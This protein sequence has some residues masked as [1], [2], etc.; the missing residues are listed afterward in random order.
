MGGCGS[1]SDQRAQSPTPVCQQHHQGGHAGGPAGALGWGAPGYQV[2][3]EA[4]NPSDPP[5]MQTVAPSGTTWGQYVR[6]GASFVNP[7]TGFLAGP[8]AECISWA[9]ILEHS[10]DWS[11]MPQYAADGVVG[12]VLQSLENSL[13][14]RPNRDQILEAAQ[15]LEDASHQLMDNGQP[16]PAINQVVTLPANAM[17][18]Q[19]CQVQNFQQPGTMMTVQVPQNA[20]PGQQ[21]MAPAPVQPH[22]SGGMS[23]GGK[24]ALAAGGAVAVGA[25]AGAAYY[26]TVGG[27]MDGLVGDVGAAGGAIGDAAGGAADWAGGAADDVGDWVGGAAGDVGD[28]AGGAAADVGEFGGEAFDGAGDFI[29]DLF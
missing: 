25:L 4:P 24:V 9:V 17:P 8:W 10:N 19:P 11:K 28:W 3:V 5:F 27:G 15:R 21:I 29:G 14:S 22:Q 20:G 2:R 6:T 16:L 12:G 13:Q 1:K 7:S 23:T 26:G 18:G